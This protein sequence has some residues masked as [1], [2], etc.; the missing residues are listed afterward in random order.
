MRL[1]LMFTMGYLREIILLMTTL[2]QLITQNGYQGLRWVVLA[3]IAHFMM[4]RLKTS[5][6]TGFK[7]ASQIQVLT[8]HRSS[9]LL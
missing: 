2:T 8:G 6:G 9:L 3:D 7:I 4:S 1:T 5:R